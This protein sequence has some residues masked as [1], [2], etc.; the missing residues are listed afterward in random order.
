MLVILGIYDK[1]I[2]SISGIFKNFKKNFRFLFFIGLGML[3]GVLLFS[4]IISYL[5]S[6]YPWQMNYLFIGLILGTFGIL[7]KAVKQFN[8]N[9]STYIFFI[10]TFL[11]LVSIRFVKVPEYSQNII[12]NLSFEN[13]IIIFISGFMASS[14]MI[15]PGLSGSF[16][17]IVFGM[18]N[19]VI[20]AVSDL[21]ILILIPFGI[22]VVLGFLFMIRVVEYLLRVFEVQTYMAILGFVVGSLILIF[23]GFEF[24]VVGLT[25]IASLIVGF[26]ISYFICKIDKGKEHAK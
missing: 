1:L 16:I 10:I 15:I 24:S 9:K 22:G 17:L 4:N 25:C 19:S 14:A 20:K 13:I 26:L 12:T 11:I 7:F 23:P 8:P 5:L 3:L 6:R 21:N 18:Y 2:K